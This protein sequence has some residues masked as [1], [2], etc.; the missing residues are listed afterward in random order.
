[1]VDTNLVINLNN[2]FQFLVAAPQR[3]GFSSRS[4]QN[5]TPE[6][7]FEIDALD[8]FVDYGIIFIG[9]SPEFLV[10]DGG[11]IVHVI[12]LSQIKSIGKLET[13]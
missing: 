10:Y 12:P 2:G 3:L 11:T 1:M 8:I 6:I 5:A 13:K 9:Y 4:E 7:R